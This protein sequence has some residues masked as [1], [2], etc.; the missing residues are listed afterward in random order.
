M[1]EFSRR[2]ALKAANITNKQQNQSAKLMEIQRK[3][4][5][6]RCG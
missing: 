5:D 2:N 3:E 6:N 1:T 4:A